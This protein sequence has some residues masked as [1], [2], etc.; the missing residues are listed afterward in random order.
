MLALPRRAVL[1]DRLARGTAAVSAVRGLNPTLVHPERL[2]NP[3]GT[4]TSNASDLGTP[5]QRFIG[6]P[7]SVCSHEV[8]WLL[9]SDRRVALFRL[10]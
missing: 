7:P 5:P 3:V 1:V 2:V 6:I 4:D 9:G 8:C 10:S